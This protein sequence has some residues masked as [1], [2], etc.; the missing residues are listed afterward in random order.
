MPDA[1]DRLEYRGRTAKTPEASH[2]LRR[3]LLEWNRLV[4]ALPVGIYVCDA[5]GFLVHYNRRAAELWG[6]SPDIDARGARYCGAHKAFTADGE[7]IS[8][9]N[10]PMAALL[11]TAQPIRDREMVIERPD[12]S[13]IT[14]LLNLDPLC[15]QDG[16]LVGGV[17]CMQDISGRK[18][19]E[20]RLQAREE[21]F[22]GLLSALAAAVYTT[23]AQGRITYYNQAAAELAGRRPELGSETWSIAS[24]LYAADGTPLRPEDYPVAVALK[25]GEPIRGAEKIAERPDGTRVPILSFPTPL[26]DDSGKLVGAVNML[27]DISD[28]K[29]VEEQKTMLVRELAH[30]VNNIFAVVLAVTQQS[31]RTAASPQAFAETFTARLQALARAHNLLLARDWAGADLEELAREQIAP[32]KPRSEEMMKIEGPKVMLKPGQVIALGAVLH[33]LAT[34]AYK[35]GAL[36]VPNG[37]VELGWVLTRKDG[38]DHVELNWHERGGPR[39]KRPAKRGLGSRII[40]RGLPG[41]TITWRFAPGGVICDI[42]LSLESGKSRDGAVPELKVPPAPAR[43]PSSDAAADPDRSR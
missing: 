23:D 1:L 16:R 40:Q 17:S 43:K 30:R 22:R 33:E 27:L 4:E 12:G 14:V 32:F 6:L 41:A 34:N 15:E 42:D 13:R 9:A 31:L 7:L 19:A 35:Y 25:T 37:T 24:R 20:A 11:A 36:S 10:G 3:A 39:V 21:W 28:R 29:A 26:R 38:V 2:A 8:S 18:A 5:Q